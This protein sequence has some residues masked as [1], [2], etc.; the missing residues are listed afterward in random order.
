MLK[1]KDIVHVTNNTE[2]SK[3]YYSVKV[4]KDVV[5]NIID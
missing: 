2:E 3:D 1:V 4:R 5:D